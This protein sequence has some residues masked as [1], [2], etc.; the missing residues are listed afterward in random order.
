MRSTK[1]KIGVACAAVS[2]LALT[3]TAAAIGSGNAAP[4]GSGTASATHSI[5]G[6]GTGK[7]ATGS[8]IRIGGIDM[9]IPGVDFTTIGKVGRGVLRVRQ[10]QRRHQRPPD[11]VHPLQRAAQPGAGGVARTE[12]DRERQGRRRRRQH[13]LRRVRYELEVL[14]EQGLRRHRRRRPGG[15]LQHPVLRRGQ[16]GPA[17]QQRRRGTG[18]DQGRREEARD[19]F[20]GHDLGVRGR[21]PGARRPEGRH[22][23]Q[24]LP[25]PPAGHRRDLAA[26][27]DVPVRR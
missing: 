15:V 11:P 7:K 12:A 26:A 3:L 4:I 5:C 13:E 17:L 25:D 2:L 20:A 14:Q 9:L 19:R 18:A 24:D 16:L 21:R 23:G 8:P 27:P 10:R 1:I 6:L 22:P